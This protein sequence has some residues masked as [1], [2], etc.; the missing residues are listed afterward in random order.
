M[1]RSTFERLWPGRP[2]QP[3]R[4]SVSSWDGSQLRILGD[5]MVL[6]SC[7]GTSRQLPIH[8][9]EG[10]GPSLL[11]RDWL[12]ALNILVTGLQPLTNVH[13]FQTEVPFDHVDIPL[14]APQPPPPAAGDVRTPPP[15]A[16]G[17]AHTPTVEQLAREFERFREGLGC[18]T[19]PPISILPDPG[20]KPIH[21][22]ARPMPF[23]MEAEVGGRAG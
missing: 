7:N 1:A 21:L 15:E 8:V 12:S 9:I 2:I 6:V 19:G 3:L 14:A 23:A 13:A 4:E 17:D 5:V 18:Y 10:D 22:K 16:A 11:G 20:V